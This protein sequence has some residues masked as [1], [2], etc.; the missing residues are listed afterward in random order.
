MATATTTTSRI[1]PDP[2]QRLWQVPMFLIGLAAFACAY[3]GWLPLGPRDS[4]RDFRTDIAA[5]GLLATK[6]N[7]DLN[8]LKANLS[9][10]A[11]AADSFPE[12]AP[13]A[14]FALGTGY[15]RLA[16]LTSDLA[17]AQ[18]SWTL[19]K[20]HFDAVRSEQLPDSSD[21][22][23][24]AYRAAKARA[25]VPAPNATMA[26]LDLTR[27]LL[28]SMPFGE[29]A[30][31]GHRLAAELGLRLVPPDLQQAKSSLIAYISETGLATPPASLARA[32]LRVSEVHRQLGDVEGAKNWLAQ[33]G[34]DA[35]PD[36]LP[37]A[38]AQLARIR[39]DEGDYS[40]ARREWEVVLAIPTL[41][42]ALK[43]SATYHLGLCLLSNKP[44][45]PVGA[46]RRFEEASK[47][48]GPEG[49][50]AS[51]KLA[52]LRLKSD[53]A[54]RRKE[55]AFYLNS[56]AKGIAAP[57]EYP[58]NALLPIQE[59]QAAFESG[60]QVL[61]LDGA[62]ESA[63]AVAD[64]YKSVAT[65]GREREKRA[66]TLAAW[67]LSLQKA[68]GEAGPKFNAAADDY[69]ALA[70][71]RIVEADKADLFR[72]AASLYRQGGKPAAA[73]GVYEQAIKLPNLS[74]EVGGPI[75]IEYAE[76]LL[77]ANRPEEAL[78]ALQVTMLKDGPAS[79]A[80]RYRVA[81]WLIDSRVAA[82]VEF[83]VALMDQVATAETVKP[84]E[85]EMHE[86]ALVDV[87]HAYIQKGNFAE[88]EARLEKQVK[89]YPSGG[90]SG[91]G[92]LLL[93][94]CLLQRADARAKPPTPNP[95]KNREEAL[96]LFKLV[97]VEV[98]VR[99][100]ENRP[101]ERDPWLKTQ[102][103][104]RV[105]QTYQQMA[106]PFD[107]LKDG[108]A[109]RRE[110][111]GT[112]DELIVLSLMYHAYKQL[113]KPEGTFAIH[114][115]MREVFEKLKDKKGAFWAKNGEYSQ[116]YWEKVWFQMDP[117]AKQP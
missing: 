101:I 42:P 38:K 59:V 84:A 56:A 47:S 41:P 44:P 18:T 98:E 100:K 2:T 25:A 43:P 89:L 74:D 46:A 72:K 36:V 88:A 115:Q 26:E 96:R 106:R 94:V 35:P 99:A 64:S 80:A 86:R 8:E 71:V 11:T 111:A 69:A 110:F 12:N 81:R 17:E 9:R 19:A 7:P 39:M 117:P 50:A 58:R 62:F 60:V 5:L 63:V 51:V 116:E 107:V 40:G 92:K 75:W 57:G 55:A 76:T 22:P 87:A 67:G 24:L 77:S 23:R 93:G 6:Q 4:A 82:K 97:V 90:E 61:A 54:A 27:R 103:N 95:A 34:P 32:K 13:E 10:V 14:H 91:L 78:K 114:A 31:E 79:T 16:E 33:I 3:Q 112:A 28:L 83:G 21:G 20:Q 15:V 48:E 109:L 49:F 37:T 30:G 68:G 108:D 104:L 65:A 113:D 73:I 85:R 45:D 29:D 102:A 53:D 105:L 52:E 1:R 70:N 66:E